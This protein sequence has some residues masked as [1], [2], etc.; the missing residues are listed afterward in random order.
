[1]NHEELIEKACQMGDLL[2]EI[3]S[4]EHECYE[5]IKMILDAKPTK[6]FPFHPSEVYLANELELME[7]EL[8][9][10][11][12][13]MQD[14]IKSSFYSEGKVNVWGLPNLDI[15]T[16][17]SVFIFNLNEKV[18]LSFKTK[19]SVILEAGTYVQPY[20]FREVMEDHFFKV[21]GKSMEM[22]FDG[23]FYV[24]V[25]SKD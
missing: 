4:P 3:L 10:L 24:Y 7:N 16:V 14:R 15:P 23:M 2:F 18:T 11:M 6:D 8:D 12:Q 1:M 9:D 21:E 19:H 22:D 17:G 5:M 20:F 13:K 25:L